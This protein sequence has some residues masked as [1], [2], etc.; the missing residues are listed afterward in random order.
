MD[1]KEHA[2]LSTHI[3]QFAQGYLETR[4]WFDSLDGIPRNKD[5][6]VP[7]ITYPAFI[8]LSRIVRPDFKVFEYGCGGSS[9]WWSG[10]VAEVTS[11]EHDSRWAAHVA[12]GAQPNLKIVVR[13][14]DEAVEEGRRA[15]VAPFFA[16]PPH[17]PLSPKEAHNRLHG[18]MSEEFVAYATE[19]M[20]FPKAHFDVI[21][22]DGM[23]R[24][25]ST[26][27]AISYLK[28]G[29]FILFDN[30]DRWQ[31]NA[32]Y[33]ML[34]AAGFRR[35]DYYGPGPVNKLEWCTSIFVRDLSVFDAAIDSASTVS[36]MGW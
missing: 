36:D 9:L 29:G 1:I 8:Q 32:A 22:I 27:V 7:W 12:E 15:A 33:Q 30:S 16:D 3:Y 18:L 13:E 31:Y 26:W 24:V 10:K 35:I 25:L 21:V 23:A 11:V 17:L 4:G 14:M 19:I 20:A 34:H 28:P 5:G 2:D 6:V